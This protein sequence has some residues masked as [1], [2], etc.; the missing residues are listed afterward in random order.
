MITISMITGRQLRFWLHVKILDYDY[1][2]DGGNLSMAT[3]TSEI[4]NGC[5][6]K[7]TTVF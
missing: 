3:I 4:V 6:I 7:E 5:C 1:E 2:F